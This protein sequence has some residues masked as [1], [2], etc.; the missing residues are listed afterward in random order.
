MKKHKAAKNT[1][2][3]RY[4]GPDDG[5]KRDKRGILI[6]MRGVGGCELET[7]DAQS[8]KMRKAAKHG[9][10]EKHL[11]KPPDHLKERDNWDYLM[12]MCGIGGG[13]K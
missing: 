10:G 13:K 7:G 8:M 5:K 11:C 12:K 4:K 6:E 2:G 9:I 3:E 1:N